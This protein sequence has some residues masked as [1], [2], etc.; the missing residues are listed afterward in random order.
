MRTS[1]AIPLTGGDEDI[2]AGLE[3]VASEAGHEG[4]GDVPTTI[5][6]VT[7]TGSRRIA[8]LARILWII[9]AT[10]GLCYFAR[11]VV[12]P[13]VLAWVAGMALKPPV[14]WL[15]DHRVPAPLA[16]AMALAVFLIPIGAGLSRIGRPAMEWIRETPENVVVLKN[17]FSK[18]LNHG[19]G[20]ATVEGGLPGGATA[21]PLE[22]PAVDLADG[23]VATAVFSW[24]GGMLALIGEFVGLL[25]LLLTS[26]DTFLAKLVKV[27]PTLQDKRRAVRI[28]HEIQQSISTYV[29]SVTVVNVVFGVIAGLVFSVTGLPHAAM[30]GA[31]VGALNFIPYFGPIVG[32]VMVGM[33]GLLA[34]ETV[35]AGLMPAAVYLVLHLIEANA[36]TPMVL[37]RRF[38]LNPVIILM[39]LIFFVWLWGVPG[40]FVAVPILVSAKVVCERSTSLRPVAEFLAR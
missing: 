9:A 26:G 3:P 5:A 21:A 17:R 15:R 29:F 8:D 30:W 31:I 18:L 6:P 27:L 16:A 11:A 10:I 33:S 20:P 24:T 35:G 37:G 39:M 23:H 38:T 14:R 28:S 12:L 40:A 19:G 25:F 2:L 22:A 34:F 4:A 7:L 1:A 32:F 13:L 36:V